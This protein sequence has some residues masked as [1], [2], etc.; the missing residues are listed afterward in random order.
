MAK[1]ANH[2]G[3]NWPYHEDIHGNMVPCA[4]NP[5]KLHGGQDIYATSLEDATEKKHSAN[6]WGFTSRE[7][8][9]LND[10]IVNNA[11]VSGSQADVTIGQ[12][13][14]ITAYMRPAK[15]GESDDRELAVAYAYYDPDWEGGSSGADMMAN[16]VRSSLKAPLHLDDDNAGTVHKALVQRIHESS[17]N[18]YDEYD[19]LGLVPYLDEDMKKAYDHHHA[20]ERHTK[21]LLAEYNAKK[22]E[23]V[24]YNNTLLAMYPDASSNRNILSKF[25]ANNTSGLYTWQKRWNDDIKPTKE[26]FMAA[27][28]Y[29]D[30]LLKDGNYDKYK[31]FNTSFSDYERT[32]LDARDVDSVDVRNGY[33]PSDFSDSY[34]IL[35]ESKDPND[36]KRMTALV[37]RMSSDKQ[38]SEFLGEQTK[39]RM[40]I[41]DNDYSDYSDSAFNE[42]LEFSK[43]ND[44]DSTRLALQL[45]ES[46]RLDDNQVIDIYNSKVRDNNDWRTTEQFVL[47]ASP[48]ADSISKSSPKAAEFI[49]HERINKARSLMKSD[50]SYERMLSM[51]SGLLSRKELENGL[52]AED[53][54]N[55]MKSMLASP[56]IDNAAANIIRNRISMRD[57]VND[58]VEGMVAD[59]KEKNGYLRKLITESHDIDTRMAAYNV[60]MKRT[61]DNPGVKAKAAYDEMMQTLRA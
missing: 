37:N 40:W 54:Y 17:L 38:L 28:G 44:Q 33:F 18:E 10:G 56:H 31:V 41:D 16:Q 20:K 43:T 36:R 26:E 50:K 48:L 32:D 24:D 39:V 46:G 27:R 6:G 13:H 60:L 19:R 9:N 3:E 15:P 47:N 59:N 4:S 49:R 25:H 34:K 8:D 23:V 51:N 35:Q 11:E 42:A 30:S 52:K 7:E 21:N 12:L 45:V 29:F 55:N 58:T 2:D 14:D 53:D 1:K 61:R 57:K 5:C 22:K